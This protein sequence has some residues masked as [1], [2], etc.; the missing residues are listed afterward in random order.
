M[1]EQGK[2]VEGTLEDLKI[3][4]E[5]EQGG[6]KPKMEGP[7]N[8]GPEVNALPGDGDIDVDQLIK[9]LGGPEGVAALTI[10]TIND[11]L[12]KNGLSPLNQLQAIMIRKG[13]AACLMK[14]NLD[15]K[16]APEE[17]L[18]LG[19]LWVLWDKIREK[20]KLDREK[21]TDKPA[22]IKGQPE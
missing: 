16:A 20:K 17:I 15:T 9:D 4:I 3:E 19:V 11:W 21:E 10:E 22:E 18:V 6:A 1:T 14:W 8:G 2:S 12:G 5:G 13:L 7:R